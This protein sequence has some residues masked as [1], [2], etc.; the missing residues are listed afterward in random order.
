[1]KNDNKNVEIKLVS[2]DTGFAYDVEITD[3]KATLGEYIDSLDAF[4][5]EKVA[6]CLGCDNC[7]YQRIPLILPD[8]Y[9]YAGSSPET[10]DRFLQERC[11][12]KKCGPALDI[13]LAQ[14]QEGICT[15]LDGEN[16]RCTDHRRRSMVCHTY[17]C[18]PQT[19]RARE[20]RETL[21]NQGEDALIGELF[22]WGLLPQYQDL[23]S[24]YPIKEHWQNR[25]YD[26]V[27]LQE[28][29]PRELWKRLR[30]PA[31]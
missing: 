28:V 27:I 5:E 2:T 4:L 7:C 25:S 10:A 13:S 30:Y 18:I 14:G 21:I 9:N 15:F 1:M 20:L 24:A 16:Q 11:T 19:P 3:P 26:R 31:L 6:S 17:I 23:S 8:I 22:A 12:I 29:L